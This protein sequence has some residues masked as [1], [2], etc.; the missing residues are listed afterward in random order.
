MTTYSY[1]RTAVTTG[2]AA[3]KLLSNLKLDLA[4]AKE[5]ASDLYG[6]TTPEQRGTVEKIYD[7]LKKLND[8]VK[9]LR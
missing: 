9:K 7:Q 8:Q 3:A 2:E 1:D 5:A 6:V 4:R